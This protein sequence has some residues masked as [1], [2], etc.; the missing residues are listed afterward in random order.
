MRERDTGL[1]YTGI[2]KEMGTIKL[3][4]RTTS[5]N[6]RRRSVDRETGEERFKEVAQGDI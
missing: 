2:T 3:N 6:M 4:E 5:H 1:A